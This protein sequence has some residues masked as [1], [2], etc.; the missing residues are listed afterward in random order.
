MDDALSF[1]SVTR[2]DAWLLSNH[3]KERERWLRIW[4][5]STTSPFV[6]RIFTM[7]RSTA[8]PFAGRVRRRRSCCLLEPVAETKGTAQFHQPR[9]KDPEDQ[10]RLHPRLQRCAAPDGLRF[11]G[12]MVCD[13]WDQ[14]RSSATCGMSLDDAGLSGIGRESRVIALDSVASQ[15]RKQEPCLRQMVCNGSSG[16]RAAGACQV[17]A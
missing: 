5:S 6:F 16:F 8:A 9:E 10:G 14:A 4:R 13:K 17:E 1:P 3:T 7:S 11:P 15:R 2:L 12:Q